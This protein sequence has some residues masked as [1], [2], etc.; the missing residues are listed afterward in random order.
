MFYNLIL[1]WWDSLH[2]Y[3]CERFDF[4]TTMTVASMLQIW[5]STDY[6][7]H[8]CVRLVEKIGEPPELM[9]ISSASH[10]CCLA[11][12]ICY[13][14]RQKNKQTCCDIDAGCVSLRKMPAALLRKPISTACIHAKQICYD[15]LRCSF[16]PVNSKNGNVHASA[17]SI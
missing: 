7:P 14:G 6:S 9:C 1:K 17:V 12:L 4:K 13:N 2:I 10:A 15:L 5:L 8:L 11:A 3:I 16:L